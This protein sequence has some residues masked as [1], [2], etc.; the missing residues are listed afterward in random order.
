MV[1]R[2]RA[3]RLFVWYANGLD[4]EYV[5]YAFAAAVDLTSVEF[6]VHNHNHIVKFYSL[7]PDGSEILVGEVSIVED[8]STGALNYQRKTVEFRGVTLSTL[9][10]RFDDKIGVHMDAGNVMLICEL[11]PYGTVAGAGKSAAV[12]TRVIIE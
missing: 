10:I 1:S 8:T 3:K 9:R 11:H 4:G 5:D 12:R 7:E 6:S 2:N